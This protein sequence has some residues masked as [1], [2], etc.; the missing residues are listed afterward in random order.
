MKNFQRE[1]SYHWV[2]QKIRHFPL[3]SKFEERSLSGSHKSQRIGNHMDGFGLEKV[4][5]AG[6]NFTAFIDVD[7]E[8]VE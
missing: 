8:S 2:E 7:A 6:P 5:L 4:Q 1:E 3:F